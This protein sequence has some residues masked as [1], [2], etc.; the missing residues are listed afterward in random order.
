MDRKHL[1]AMMASWKRPPTDAEMA[2][3]REWL[4][5]LT[6][7]EA[8]KLV[9]VYFRNVIDY[10]RSI[11][12]QYVWQFANRLAWDDTVI[13]PGNI[14]DLLD[15]CSGNGSTDDISVRGRFE[16][17]L[18]L[19]L[20][21][22]IFDEEKVFPHEDIH[23]AL[24]RLT[25]LFKAKLFSG[26]CKVK[27]TT[28]HDPEDDFM[29]VA[30]K[31]GGTWVK[32]ISH[33]KRRR[34]VRRKQTLSMRQLST[35]EVV[36]LD[37]RVKTREGKAMKQIGQTLRKK[38]CPMEVR[39]QCGLMLVA[40]DVGA[41]EILKIK[42]RHMLA[43]V[44]GEL[45]DVRSNLRTNMAKD[46][47]NKQSSPQHKFEECRIYWEG[48]EYEVQFLTTDAYMSSLHSCNG[49]NHEL[50]RLDQ[51][52]HLFLPRLFPVSIYGVDWENEKIRKKIRK[53]MV[54]KLGLRMHS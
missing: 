19:D 27:I 48:S 37:A 18:A 23:R 8:R 33:K 9:E 54:R 1:L 49:A 17:I 2:E 52:L 5:G 31:Q 47:T 10:R 26:S 28:F 24:G 3:R 44:G 35:G 4:S 13:Y 29:V 14:H 6:S 16:A 15:V 30:L 21:R 46:P 20:T 38:P 39:D 51:M 53:A 42:I 40:P 41:I 25:R 34:C 22:M 32:K 45:H 7:E 43:E 50:Y 36:F 12:E 11:V